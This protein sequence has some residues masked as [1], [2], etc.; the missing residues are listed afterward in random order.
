MKNLTHVSLTRAVTLVILVGSIAILSMLATSWSTP[1]QSIYAQTVPEPPV[2]PVRTPQGSLVQEPEVP[3]IQAEPNDT[4]A[5]SN[6]A[7]AD[8]DQS[9]ADEQ[10]DQAAPPARDST[11]ETPAEAKPE[12]TQ[13]KQT[14]QQ[15][16]Q[17]KKPARVLWI[18]IADNGIATAILTDGSTISLGHISTLS[19]RLLTWFGL[20]GSPNEE[21]QTPQQAEVQQVPLYAL[22]VQQRFA[23]VI[24]FWHRFLPKTASSL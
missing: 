22:Q 11:K 20:I 10:A 2:T 1:V 6:D 18:D 4:G 7:T 17:P 23:S 9:A 8:T 3:T 12:N 24:K 19:P 13:E 5:E 21:A 16:N 15:T 14:N